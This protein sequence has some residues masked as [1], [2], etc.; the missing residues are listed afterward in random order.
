LEPKGT[1]GL[2][3]ADNYNSVVLLFNE[4]MWRGDVEILL[5]N[6]MIARRK[7]DGDWGK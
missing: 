7:D 5:M 1:N 2:V 4:L 3:E 6:D